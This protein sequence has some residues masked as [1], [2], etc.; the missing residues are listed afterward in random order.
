MSRAVLGIGNEMITKTDVYSP[1]LVALTKYSFPTL[2][3][4]FAILPSLASL[5]VF[6]RK[7]RSNHSILAQKCWFYYMTRCQKVETR[8]W[9]WLL[10]TLMSV[11]ALLHVR[12]SLNGGNT[13]VSRRR[14]IPV[15]A[16]ITAVMEF[17][18]TFQCNMRVIPVLTPCSA[19]ILKAAG[20]SGI[21]QVRKNVSKRNTAQSSLESRRLCVK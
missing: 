9:H 12:C 20:H 10:G 3:V 19:R 17:Y 1:F 5:V 21:L 4:A 13:A 6:G 11:Q 18:W 7:W 14:R 16:H 8:P 15:I 2:N